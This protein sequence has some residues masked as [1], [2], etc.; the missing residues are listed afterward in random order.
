MRNFPNFIQKDIYECGLI[1]IKIISKYYN[2]SFSPFNYRGFINK[3]RKGISIKDL[4]T[5][6]ENENY[7]AKSF[8]CDLH[9]LKTLELPII[10]LVN[11]HYSV[12][13]KYKNSAFYISDPQRGLYSINENDFSNSFLGKDSLGKVIYLYPNNQI[14]NE[15]FSSDFL[16]ASRFFWTNLRQ[17]KRDITQNIIIM[18]IIALIYGML[19]FISRAVIDIGINSRDF[20]FVYL[21]LIASILLH[22]FKSIGEWIKTSITTYLSSKIKISITTNYI[23]K[24]FKLPL[25]YFYKSSFG[26]IVQRIQDQDKLQSYIAN[27]LLSIFLSIMIFIIYSFI[28]FF[29]NHNLFIIFFIP[30]LIYIIYTICFHNFRK[31]IE[32]DSFS[33]QGENQ[34]F[35]METLKNIEDIKLNN[36]GNLQRKKWEK[37]HHKIFNV[38]IKTMHLDRLQKLGSDLLSSIKDV[39]ITL[40]GAYLVINGNISFG[41]LI[42][43]QFIIGQ[44]NTPIMEIINFIKSSQS[45]LINFIK[46]NDIY[47][48]E[49]EQNINSGTISNFTDIQHKSILFNNVSFRYHDNSPPILNNINIKIENNKIVAIVGKSGSGKTTILKLIS[50]IHSNYS[51]NISINGI[52]LKRIENNFWRDNIGC[53]FQESKLYKGSILDNITLTDS[54]NFDEN[55]VNYSIK[56]ANL[57]DDLI[58]FP[59]GVYT[60]IKENETGISQGQKQRIIIARNIYKTPKILLLDEATNTLDPHS[61]NIILSYIK[62]QC[63]EKTIVIASHKLSTIKI[64]DEIIVLDRGFIVEKGSFDNLVSNK[65]S[66]FYNLFKDQLNDEQ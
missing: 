9:T 30:T 10:I 28:L 16:G 4:I 52:N 15:N 2:R 47:N 42:S 37:T 33:L 24:L 34:S 40:Y 48:T 36:I 66:F 65:K 7:I 59:N 18:F 46:I 41:T 27:S 39:S 57:G 44:L 12:L 31:K 56:W 22:V 38:N 26:E 62:E 43:I 13:Y 8:Y 25:D 64:A 3:E 51:G 32:L 50:K 45:A 21:I 60:T 5:I 1:C 14:I 11:H 58:K 29:F 35:W 17:Y 23:S 20:E 6:A 19:P 61:E 53:I 63:T 49:N 55:R 54:E